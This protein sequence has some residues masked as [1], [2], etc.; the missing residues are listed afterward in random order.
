MHILSGNVAETSQIAGFVY[1]TIQASMNDIVDEETQQKMLEAAR[2]RGKQEAKK[3]MKIQFKIGDVKMAML[4]GYGLNP[5]TEGLLE[6]VVKSFETLVDM[7]ADGS[8]NVNVSLESLELNDVSLDTRKYSY[9]FKCFC[10]C[11]IQ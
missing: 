11:H 7:Q 1:P 5:K 8:L 10:L 2:E 6:F 4:K 3:G 9:F